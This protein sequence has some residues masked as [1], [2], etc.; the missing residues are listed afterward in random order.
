MRR[1]AG[2]DVGSRAVV[3]LEFDPR[4]RTVPMHPHFARALEANKPAKAAF[5]KLAPSRKKEILRYLGFMKTATSL[6]RNIVIIV[7]YL[8]G[9]E[10]AG[11]HALLRWKS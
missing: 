6:R 10:P 7:D 8:S 5:E 3:E 9:R 4:P 1:G 2:I 11:L